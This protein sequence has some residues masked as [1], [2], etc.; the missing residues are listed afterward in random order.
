MP[1]LD[2]KVM[3]LKTKAV[4]TILLATIVFITACV[5]SASGDVPPIPTGFAATAPLDSQV[6]LTWAA[7]S[8][9][10]SY[11]IYRGSAPG[12][13]AL[14]QAGVLGTT[15]ED[16]GLGDGQT[17]Y[18]MVTAVN[19]SGE[20]GQSSEV[21]ATTMASS[22]GNLNAVAG[23]SQVVLTWNCSPTATGYRLYRDT[24]GGPG[25]ATNFLVTGTNFTD[26][27]L[28]NGTSYFYQIGTV[29]SSGENF[30][31]GPT[32]FATPAAGNSAEAPA[33]APSNL[34]ATAG[35][36]VVTVSWLPVSNASS[37]NVFRG[38]GSNMETLLQTGVVSV[39]FS[40]TGLTNG[41][42]YYY[43]VAAVNAGQS[44][45][46]S[47]ETS[48][49]PYVPSAPTN[50]TTQAQSHEV[51]LTWAGN[52]TSYAVYRGIASGAETLLD[53]GLTGNTF[54]DAGVVNGTTYFYKIRCLNAGGSGPLSA[55]VSVT[56]SGP[57]PQPWSGTINFG[58]PGEP[59]QS[60][61]V[62]IPDT[63]R[64][65]QFALLT[66]EGPNM[67]ALAQKYNAII[68][69]LD[70]F[71]GF[72]FGTPGSPIYLS[73]AADS[74]TV[75]IF[76]Y[77]WPQLAAQRIQAALTAAAQ[78]MPSH[79]EIKNTGL[80]MYGFSEGV[81]NVNEAVA[82]PNLLNRV[83]AVINLSEID[84]DRNN[85]LVIM[86][87]APHLFLASGLS[88]KFSS[89]NQSLEDFSNVTH[90]AFSRGLATTQGA[91]LTV[92][93]NV[94]TGH[95]GN[96]DHPFISLWLD[97]ILSQRLPANLP[98]SVPVN[99]PTWQGSSSWVGS[100]D[101]TVNSASPWNSGV[102]MINNVIAAK[103]AYADPRPFTWLPGRNTA[104]AWLAYA[105]SGLFT[106]FNPVIN[107]SMSAVV[108]VGQSLSYEI[109]AINYPTGY[110]ATN[111]PDG[112]S[113]DPVTG[114]ISG[115]PDASGI[116]PITITATNDEGTVTATLN[117]TVLN[118]FSIQNV[119]IDP[120][121]GDLAMTY[122]TLIGQSYTIQ[123]ATNL[124]GC[125]ITI[126]NLTATASTT[127]STLSK[128]LLD[129]I[130]GNAP[131]SQAYFR[132]CAP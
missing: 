11:N 56:P 129:S 64:P 55:E 65:V 88:D 41:V 86:D 79:L 121:S 76:D 54:T 93:D 9:A 112:L 75:S 36:G 102:Q 30:N 61:S 84:E 100:Y 17:F 6:A 91:P 101:V 71:S 51:M 24:L 52:G 113:I 103:P 98:V 63:N 89:L 122:E 81:D 13:E 125:W 16:S 4:I 130:S 62:S 123:G 27:G 40:D 10:T 59:V 22:P 15:F 48:A 43:E 38:T 69:G 128:A 68:F 99:L 108:K 29:N 96:P 120:A 73:T 132:V 124:T 104:T 42:A 127:T 115:T 26:T 53:T 119:S 58:L 74:H 14:L 57:P 94:G 60:C 114:I 33:G 49:T 95:G 97:S 21:S 12:G 105:N 131:R 111:L 72:N 35:N 82:Q 80:V 78:I 45:P 3:K 87:S 25:G 116:F 37:Y 23:D 90:D 31:T 77:R 44:S 109:T 92:L 18:Y 85:P 8:G 2:R 34:T 67:Q 20:S 19:G 5:Q 47:T 83:L 106:A 117:L 32:V 118:P 28:V 39:T 126:S 110:D 107:S 1:E 7:S 50:L 70:G 46:L 66:A